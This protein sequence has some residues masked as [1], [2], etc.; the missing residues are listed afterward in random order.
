MEELGRVHQLIVPFFGHDMTFNLEVMVMTWLVIGSLLL[1]GFL[2]SRKRSRLPGPLQSVGELFV[3]HLYGLTED[4]L[5][6]EKAKTYAP[7]ICALF[8]FLVL[9]NWFGIIPNLEEPTK[10]LNT[11]LSLGLMGF[12][13]AHYAGIKAKGFKEYVKE[14]FQP[15]FFMMPLNVIGELAKVVSISFRLFGN[16]MGGS[17]IILVVSYLTYSIIFPPLLNAFFG[18]FVGTIQAFVFTMLTVVYISVQVR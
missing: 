13:I 6:K 1:F 8:M 14:Y 9:S 7:L 16:I 17:I 18:L 15:I 5:G 2:A 10:D 12:V 11:P 3:V 4:A